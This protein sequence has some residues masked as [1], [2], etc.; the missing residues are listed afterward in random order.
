MEE[1]DEGKSLIQ[2]TILWIQDTG[3]L[4]IQDGWLEVNHVQIAFASLY[5]KTKI[6]W[7]EVDCFV[8]ALD[9]NLELTVS[10]ML[11]PITETEELRESMQIMI[12][13]SQLYQFNS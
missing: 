5:K 2:L 4:V 11:Q 12:S 6:L 7:F 8:E 1:I 13:V 9:S 10:G 3:S